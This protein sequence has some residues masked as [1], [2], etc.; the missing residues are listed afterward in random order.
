MSI[1]HEND[2]TLSAT[3]LVKRPRP[4]SLLWPVAVESQTTLAVDDNDHEKQMPQPWFDDALRVGGSNRRRLV[5]CLECGS[6]QIQ[7]PR[8]GFGCCGD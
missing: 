3:T 1:R 5:G 4:F 6:F 7:A 2:A 8:C